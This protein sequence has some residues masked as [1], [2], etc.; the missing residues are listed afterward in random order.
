MLKE[1]NN[2]LFFLMLGGFALIIFKI[3]LFDFD[4]IK[5]CL[6]DTGINRGV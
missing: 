6:V 5:I 2:S 3:L 1:G 4:R